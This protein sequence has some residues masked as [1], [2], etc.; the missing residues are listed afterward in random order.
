MGICC[1]AQ[2][3]QI[4]TLYQ[5]RGVRWGGR[6]EGVSQG[7]GY[8][9]TYGWFMLRFD[10]K[11]QNSVKQLSFSK[12]QISL[13]KKKKLCLSSW[14]WNKK[15]HGMVPYNTTNPLTHHTPLHTLPFRDLEVPTIPYSKAVTV[16]NMD[17][18]QIS[19]VEV[20]PVA[21]LNWIYGQGRDE[22]NSSNMSGMKSITNNGIRTKLL[23][24]RH[25]RYGCILDM[26]CIYLHASNWVCND[27]CQSL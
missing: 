23:C 11:Q 5:P 13:K 22:T 25:S 20:N 17:F 26:T 18:I 12:K 6:W 8:L 2:E 27:Y 10:R 16:L 19:P 14:T 24:F 21:H 9:Y 7:R 15:F 1:M 4:R 3:T